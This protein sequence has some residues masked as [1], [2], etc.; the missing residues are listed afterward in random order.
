M[1]SIEEI[2]LK[3]KSQLDGGLADWGLMCIVFLL[4]V[5]SFGLGRLS[6]LELDRPA[7]AIE[8]SEHLSRPLGMYIGGL[9]EASRGSKNYYFP[10]CAGASKIAPDQ[11]VWF[12]SES[13]AQAAGFMPASNCKGLGVE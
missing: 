11:A 6:D 1:A 9:F 3:I 10:W 8:N 12:Q 7:V 2:S 5:G 4:S 13:D